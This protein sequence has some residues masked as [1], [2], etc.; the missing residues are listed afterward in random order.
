MVVPIGIFLGT[1]T[2]LLSFW[3]ERTHRITITIT[4][5]EIFTYHIWNLI[6]NNLGKS[7]PNLVKRL[8]HD[9][10]LHYLFLTASVLKAGLVPRL[11]L[12]AY[13]YKHGALVAKIFENQASV[14]FARYAKQVQTVTEIFL[15]P[16]LMIHALIMWDRL[17]LLAAV[18]DIVVF[19]LF[20]ANFDETHMHFWK[21]IESKLNVLSKKYSNM[22]V[23]L[24]HAGFQ[25]LDQLGKGL[26][27]NISYYP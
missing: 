27:C 3:T 22:F 7:V 18:M 13:A 17:T 12:I 26:Y 5:I 1:M 21:F 24:V 11:L 4:V 19:L 2:S 8:W 6:I 20:Q 16:Y 15:C 10:D 25:W 14:S 9:P 23:S